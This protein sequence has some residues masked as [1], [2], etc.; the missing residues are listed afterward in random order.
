[1]SKKVG[2]V[3][4][5]NVGKSLFFNK[6]TK[7][8]QAR[9]ENF[10]FCTIDPNKGK[11]VWKDEKL[12]ALGTN[13]QHIIYSEIEIHDIAGLIKGAHEGAGLGT[14]FLGHIRDVDLILHVVRGFENEDIIHVEGAISPTH[15]YDVVRAELLQADIAH[16]EKKIKKSKGEE[17]KKLEALHKVLPNLL[18]GQSIPMHLTEGLDLLYFKPEIVILNGTELP[19]MD[20]LKDTSYIATDVSTITDE[21][22]GQICQKIYDKLD[23]IC[24]FTTGKQETRAWTTEKGSNAMV[25]AGKIHTDFCKKFVK[26][27]VTKYGTTTTKM[28]GKDYIVQH[29]DIIEFKIAK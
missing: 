10:P 5:P 4:L 7:T 27:M 24:Y 8:N 14:Q 9:S 28:E 13:S 3:G 22:I 16:I 2:V 29:T 11:L 6:V 25:A 18:F 1:M 15:D 20:F 21:T 26:A 17:L 23:L 12:T 19:N